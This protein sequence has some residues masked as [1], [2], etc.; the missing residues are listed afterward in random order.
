MSFGKEYIT[1]RVRFFDGLAKYAFAVVIVISS[2]LGGLLISAD[3]LSNLYFQNL[4][5]VGSFINIIFGIVLLYLLNK[6]YIEIKKLN[7]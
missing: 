1:E 6:Q 7:L 3:K 2:G 4:M 5:L